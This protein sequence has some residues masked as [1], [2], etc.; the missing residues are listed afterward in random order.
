MFHL[1]PLERM[2]DRYEFRVRDLAR[3]GNDLRV[4][5]RPQGAEH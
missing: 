4:V 3:V 2:A 5:L 1:P